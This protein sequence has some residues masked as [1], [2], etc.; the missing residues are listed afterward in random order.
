MA[1]RIGGG[2]WRGEG[3]RTKINVFLPQ[4][5]INTTISKKIFFAQPQLSFEKFRPTTNYIISN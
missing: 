3:G 5:A 1:G 4:Y 2:G